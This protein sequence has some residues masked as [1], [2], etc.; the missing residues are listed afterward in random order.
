[1]VDKR[2]DPFG[3]EVHAQLGERENAEPVAQDGQRNDRDREHGAL[4]WR[5]QKEISGHD[6]G[7]KQGDGR[8]DAAALRGHLEHDP[9]QM[10]NQIFAQDGGAGSTDHGVGGVGRAMLKETLQRVVQG[11]GK[12]SHEDE[13]SEGENKCAQELPTQEPC[14]YTGEQQDESVHL[15]SERV[16]PEKRSIALLRDDVRC[17][18]RGPGAQQAVRQRPVGLGTGRQA[19]ALH[20]D[21]VCT[22][23]RDERQMRVERVGQG[24]ADQLIERQAE[25]SHQHTDRHPQSDRGCFGYSKRRR[26]S[27]AGFRQGRIG[28]GTRA[29]GCVQ[30]R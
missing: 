28:H 9:G 30:K 25:G 7:D 8:A 5:V 26:R 15:P 16:L 3:T 27:G 24:Q 22:D 13:K 10:E 4:P 11:H 12:R 17:N 1:M 23:G 20:P 18:G 29:A 19:A 6:A 14:A 2:V 21:Q